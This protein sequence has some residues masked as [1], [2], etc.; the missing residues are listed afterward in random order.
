LS[1]FACFF[2][3]ENNCNYRWNWSKMPVK[4]D[5]K[6]GQNTVIFAFFCK[7]FRDFKASSVRKNKARIAAFCPSGYNQFIHGAAV[8]MPML[9]I[10]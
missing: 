2:C 5:G 4:K 6:K 10:P 3:A 9:K 1:F 8:D 7:N